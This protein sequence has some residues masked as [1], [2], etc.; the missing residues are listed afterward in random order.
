M[1]LESDSQLGEV[2]MKLRHALA[3]TT[4]G[5]VSVLGSAG[6]AAAQ[7]TTT[8]QPAA[9]GQHKAAVCAKAEAR[10]PTLQSRVTTLEDRIATL[11]TKLTQAQGNNHPDRAKAIQSR[12]TWLQTVHDHVTGTITQIQTRCAV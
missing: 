3:A 2:S 1:L 5:V 8:T 6:I 10:I 7:D 9:A 4:I 12:I 11:N